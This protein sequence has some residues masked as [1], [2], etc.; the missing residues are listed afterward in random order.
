MKRKVDITV[1]MEFVAKA[2]RDMAAALKKIHESNPKHLARYEFVLTSAIETT[3][4][5]IELSEMDIKDRSK[6]VQEAS[7]KQKKEREALMS[8]KELEMKKVLA[9]NPKDKM[10][11][12]YLERAEHMQA[13]P[14]GDD[15]DGVWVL[16]SK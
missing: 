6:N 13:N 14:P 3:S 8:T 16:K 12:M 5:S 9:L 4:D 11:Q 15:W 7:S 2:E 1:G 10:A